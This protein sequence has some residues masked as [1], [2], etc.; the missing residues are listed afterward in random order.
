MYDAVIHELEAIRDKSA[1]GGNNDWNLWDSYWSDCPYAEGGPD[2]EWGFGPVQAA[3]Y[4]A[5]CDAGLEHHTGKK[6]RKGLKKLC[7]KLARGRPEDGDTVTILEAEDAGQYTPL[8]AHTLDDAIAE[9]TA[10]SEWS[11]EYVHIYDAMG[12]CLSQIRFPQQ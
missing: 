8:S 5:A 9:V 7:K 1:Y 2:N 12:D 11:A 4:Q 3:A 10:S 6:L